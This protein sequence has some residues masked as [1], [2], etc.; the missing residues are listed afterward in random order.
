VINGVSFKIVG[1]YLY[2]PVESNQTFPSKEAAR[3]ENRK[4]TKE[5]EAKGMQWKGR[6]VPCENK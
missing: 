6:V 5:A 3:A 4:W 2:S 1:N